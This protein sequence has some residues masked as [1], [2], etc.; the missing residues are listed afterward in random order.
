MNFF[1]KGNF[2]FHFCIFDNY[3]FHFHNILK[4]DIM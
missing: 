4:F 1:K 3:R 2:Y